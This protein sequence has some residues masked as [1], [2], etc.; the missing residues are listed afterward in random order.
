[1]QKLRAFAADLELGLIADIGYDASPSWLIGESSSF[2]EI[3]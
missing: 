2:L 3:K 1:M